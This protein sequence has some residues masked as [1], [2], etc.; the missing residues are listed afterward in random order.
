M[1][2]ADFIQIILFKDYK[3]LGKMMASYGV[4]IAFTGHYHAQNI[5]LGNFGDD[6]YIY[7]IE[8][9]SLITSPCPMRYCSINNNKITIESEKLVDK[10]YPDTEFAK[11]AQ[12]LIRCIVIKKTYNTLRKC[13]VSGKDSN[14]IAD[15]LGYA[16]LAHYSGYEN[17]ENKPYFNESELGVWGRI[18]YRLRKY[19]IDGLWQDLPPD[20]NN[21]II[22]LN[23]E[24]NSSLDAVY[25]SELKR[26]RQKKRKPGQAT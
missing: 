15:N 20:D 4:K 13:Y 19:V 9:G 7:D 14:Y 17:I 8:T 21:L 26:D 2:K 16:F 11:N 23:K 5:A 6:G 24:I 10:L 3:S 12:E 18:I 22:N 1:V 25:D